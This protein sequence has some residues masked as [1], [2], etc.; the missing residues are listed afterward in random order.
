M[1]TGDLVLQPSEAAWYQALHKA[2]EAL[3]ELN[4]LK[5]QC[6]TMSLPS[7][8]DTTSN[9]LMAVKTKYQPLVTEVKQLQNILSYI[10]WLVKVQEIRY[11]SHYR[12]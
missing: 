3:E 12:N 10:S 5:Q 2:K 8:S 7:G 4:G 11:S 9:K 1:G 6:A